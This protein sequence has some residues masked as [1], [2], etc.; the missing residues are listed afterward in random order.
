MYYFAICHL[1]FNAYRLARSLKSIIQFTY[2]VHVSFVVQ[3]LSNLIKRKQNIPNEQQTQA[4][5][6][7]KGN[8]NKKENA[9]K[10]YY[11]GGLYLIY[12]CCCNISTWKKKCQNW[13]ADIVKFSSQLNLIYFQFLD[14]CR[15]IKQIFG[16]LY[17]K[18]KGKDAFI[19]VPKLWKDMIERWVLG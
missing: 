6:I 5:T 4:R 17:I 13:K 11:M 14:I 19:V 2:H 8:H 1:L 16:V 18:C 3:I 12:R 10:L 9:G 15:A 7:Y